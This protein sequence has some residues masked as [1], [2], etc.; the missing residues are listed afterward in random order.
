MSGCFRD[1]GIRGPLQIEMH[2]LLMFSRHWLWG[3]MFIEMNRIWM[4]SRHRAARPNAYRDAQFVDVFET[5][6]T[7]PCAY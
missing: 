2:R 5:L 1:T 4:F 6:A 3:P 7:G